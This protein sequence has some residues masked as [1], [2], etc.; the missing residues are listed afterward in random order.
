MGPGER[1]KFGD[2]IFEPEVLR[3]QMYCFE[4]SSYDIVVTFWL[5]E[6]IRHLGKCAP[7]VTSLVL[8]NKNRNFFRK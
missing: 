5:P 7:L 8:C 3:K 6:M 4:K 2:P 1:N